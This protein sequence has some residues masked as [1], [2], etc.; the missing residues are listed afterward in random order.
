MAAIGQGLTSLFRVL[1]DPRKGER[2]SPVPC[3]STSTDITREGRYGIWVIVSLH[4]NVLHCGL[5]N[6]KVSLG[7][8]SSSS[9]SALTLWKA[10]LPFGSQVSHL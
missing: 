1:A 4:A 3:F 10:L 6:T 7:Y 5:K 8:L 9:L 2:A